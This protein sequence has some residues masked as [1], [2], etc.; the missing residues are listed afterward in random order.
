[1]N[2]GLGV[3]T[4]GPQ[5]SVPRTPRSLWSGDLNGDGL[6]EVAG[7]D[8]ETGRLLVVPNEAGLLADPRTL[9]LP[10]ISGMIAGGDAD[11]DGDV[12]LMVSRASPGRVSVLLN[13][14]AGALREGFTQELAASPSRVEAA[15][16]DRDGRLDLALALEEPSRAGVPEVRTG[17][18]RVLRGRGDGSFEE[19][20]ALEVGE[21]ARSVDFALG[22]MDGNGS[23]DLVVGAGLDCETCPWITEGIL[24]LRN[25]SRPPSSSDTEGDGVPDECQGAAVFRRGDAAADAKLDLTDPLAILDHLFRGGAEPGCREAADAD[26]DGSLRI[27]DAI[28]LLG[29]LFLGGPPPPEPGPPPGP[30]GRDTD[31]AGSAGDLGCGSYAGCP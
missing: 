23:Q 17:R 15:D 24:L 29:H 8:A 25:G 30:C 1:M 31:P 16:I 2:D 27:T 10:G 9:A 19:T 3:F 28:F 21:G 12:D 26:N 5:V 14:G 4:R 20:M 11:G 13:D 6:P 22:D 18:V 7:A